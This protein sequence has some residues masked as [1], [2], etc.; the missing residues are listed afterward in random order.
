MNRKQTPP[1]PKHSPAPD[2]PRAPR[3]DG[4][5][6]RERLLWAGLQ[7]FANQGFAKTSTRELAEAASVNVAAIS[8][9]FGD[10]AGLYR[11]VFLEPMGDPGQLALRYVDPKITLSE[12]LSAFYADFLE[13]LKQ[14]DMARLCMKLHFRE[15]VEP[16]GMG[17]EGFAREL[18]PLHD[19]MVAV[20]CRHLGLAEA[21]DDLLRLVTC[22]AGLGVHM[23][24]GRDVTDRLAPSLNAGPDAIELWAAR[25]QMFG[26]AMVEAEASRRVV[27]SAGRGRR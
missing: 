23:H 3:A 12:A 11:A 24:L 1:G 13:P 2:T 16:T 7:L 8:Y 4:E 25:L 26:L 17:V 21:D 27:A 14:G 9:Y 6:S 15:M 20:L 19:A 22:L 10:K 18:R 5:A